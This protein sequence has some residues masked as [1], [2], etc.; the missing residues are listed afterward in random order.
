M[1]LY[2]LTYENE[3]LV[4]CVKPV[5]LPEENYTLVE[6]VYS[7]NVI[8]KIKGTYKWDIEKECILTDL[9]ISKYLEKLREIEN[10]DKIF[11]NIRETDLNESERIKQIFIVLLSSYLVYFNFLEFPYQIDLHLLTNEKLKY[12]TSFSPMNQLEDSFMQQV[13][14]F[15]RSFSQVFQISEEIN[16]GLEKINNEVDKLVEEVKEYKRK[17]LK[18]IHIKEIKKDIHNIKKQLHRLQ[19]Q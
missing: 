18:E 12:F 15:H 2:N 19:K 3:Y 16:D 17:F 1:R 7:E 13:S 6:I 11:I 14:I 8:H 5:S 4:S 9:N 10:K